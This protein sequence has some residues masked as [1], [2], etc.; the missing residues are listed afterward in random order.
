LELLK[1][2]R[3]NTTVDSEGV[4]EGLADPGDLEKFSFSLLFPVGI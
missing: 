2:K 4:A 3:K 1:K